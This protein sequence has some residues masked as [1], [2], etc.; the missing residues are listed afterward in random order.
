MFLQSETS[1]ARVYHAPHPLD[2]AAACLSPYSPVAAAA[3]AA[4]AAQTGWSNGTATAHL[5]AGA[6]AAHLQSEPLIA[7]A[8]PHH[9]AHHPRVYST[10]LP[11]QGIL[12]PQQKGSTCPTT[13]GNAPIVSLMKHSVP[14]SG[15]PVS[16]GQSTVTVAS[17]THQSLTSVASG[18]ATA[19]DEAKVYNSNSVLSHDH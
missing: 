9:L 13:T 19:I 14:R 16:N 15:A 1:P 3:A 8:P 18:G 7:L 17:S 12:Q 11:Q 2:A 4:A 5:Q 10:Y 6:A